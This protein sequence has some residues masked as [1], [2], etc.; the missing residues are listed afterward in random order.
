M[1]KEET[2]VSVGVFCKKKG[3]NSPQII[4]NKI[5]NGKLKKDIEWREIEITIKKKQICLK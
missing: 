3:I 1:A 5:A 2:W 4:Y